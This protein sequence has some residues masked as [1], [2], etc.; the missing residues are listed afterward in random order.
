MIFVVFAYQQHVT[1]KKASVGQLGG[2]EG[3]VGET[4]DD[5]GGAGEMVSCSC[6]GGMLIEMLK[7][8]ASVSV[9]AHHV[10][11]I[12]QSLTLVGGVGSSTMSSFSM[13]LVILVWSPFYMG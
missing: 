13:V 5:S 11:L 10:H 6:C 8:G 12:S 4:N 2:G 1:C 3:T 7:S 9:K